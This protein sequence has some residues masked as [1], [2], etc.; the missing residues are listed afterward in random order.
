MKIYSQKLRHISYPL[1]NM[2]IAHINFVVALY[3]VAKSFS[4]FPSVY[5][6]QR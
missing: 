2:N 3:L 5:L 4:T 6:C 1:L